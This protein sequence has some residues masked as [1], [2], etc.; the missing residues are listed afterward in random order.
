MS[1]RGT[2]PKVV[3]LIRG[4]TNH[5]INILNNHASLFLFGGSNEGLR[6]NLYQAALTQ[7]T[8]AYRFYLGAWLHPS[9]IFQ[10]LD[11]SLTLPRVNMLTPV[12]TIG[13]I[14]WY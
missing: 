14:V 2:D 11:A 12:L 7:N 8:I 4:E 1:L 10:D 13:E 3:R 5:I 9:K 6:R